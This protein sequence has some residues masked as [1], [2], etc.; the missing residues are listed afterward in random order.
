MK[1]NKT[2]AKSG[3]QQ[4]LKDE[5]SSFGEIYKLE[6]LKYLGEY[7]KGQYSFLYAN[8]YGPDYY[9]VSYDHTYGSITIDHDEYF[10]DYILKDGKPT[11]YY[12]GE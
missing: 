9:T 2:I 12:G 5:N 7:V 6:K 11:R 1:L 3:M 10:V 8:T 4:Y